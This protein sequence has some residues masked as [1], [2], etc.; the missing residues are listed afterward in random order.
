MAAGLKVLLCG[1][2]EQAAW[3][4]LESRLGRAARISHVYGADPARTD[5]FARRHGLEPVRD[6]AGFLA[7]G[8]VGAVDVC[9]RHDRHAELAALALE[10]GRPVL[11]EKPLATDLASAEGLVAKAEA[12]GLA[13]G[14]LYHKRCAPQY[15][16]LREFIRAGG[17]GPGPLSLEMSIS[18]ARD[19]AYFGWG[20]SWKAS[21]ALSGG[22]I[23]MNQMVHYLDLLAWWL[24]PVAEVE[25]RFKVGERPLEGESSADLGLRFQAG[26]QARFTATVAVRKSLPDRLAVHGRRGSLIFSGV[27]LV[28]QTV[29]FEAA[30]RFRLRPLDRLL[31]RLPYRLKRRLGWPLGRL[32]QGSVGLAWESF[33]HAAGQGLAPEVSGR[34]GLAALRIADLAYSGQKPKYIPVRG[35]LPPV[36]GQSPK[37]FYGR[38]AGREKVDVIL[39]NPLL[40]SSYNLAHAHIQAHRPRPPIGLA[41]AAAWLQRA[42]LKARVIDAA[43]FGWSPAQT[44]EMIKSFSPGLL[45]LAT[46]QLDRWQNPDLDISAAAEI[47]A[48]AGIKPTVLV[49]PHGSA[50]A[51]WTLRR[52]GADLV[53]RG[54]PELSLVELAGAV[55]GGG[56]RQ[57]VAG[58]AWLE[59]QTLVETAPRKFDDDLDEYPSPAYADLPL[60]RYQYTS[61]DL[62]GRYCSL[63]SS[64][65]CPA[66]CLFCLK[67]MMPGKWRAQSAERVVLEMELLAG[68][69]GIGSIYFQDWEFLHDR[70]RALRL[71]ELIGQRGLKLRWGFSTRLNN[72]TEAGLVQTLA[73]AGCVMINSGYETGSQEILNRARKGVNL[74]AAEAAVANCRRSGINLRL[75]GLVNL[76]GESLRSI[77]ESMRFL[78][79]LGTEV[80]HP[81]LPI[82]YPGTRLWELSGGRADWE[83]LDRYTGRVKAGLPPGLALAYFRHL[84][85]NRRFGRGYPLRPRFWRYLKIRGF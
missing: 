28:H 55:L 82:P 56:R 48:R 81:N 70:A 40:V 58:L 3:H 75:F 62:P 72:L 34:E 59:G 42:G 23:L 21:L 53:V 63:L 22:G 51:E 31:D 73:E 15:L 76:P 12:K 1:T 79:R 71:A 38:L 32:D 41:S 83:G 50:T 46:A 19:E 61:D 68:E 11:V 44:A 13:L 2:G 30:E 29:G 20:Q 66:R 25:A 84:D 43:T 4:L 69:F 14:V 9:T 78:R 60:S 26:H 45:V 8:A 36:F 17:F 39:V 37:E 54:E 18:H 64:R 47:A 80:V 67:A 7:S 6:L 27:R 35:M 16:A 33:F 5:D 85:R 65:G 24:G 10:A 74:E 57:D 49:G 77:G 52:S